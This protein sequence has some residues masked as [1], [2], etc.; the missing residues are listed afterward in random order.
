M[1]ASGARGTHESNSATRPRALHSCE[2]QFGSFGARQCP[3]VSR[4]RALPGPAIGFLKSLLESRHPQRWRPALLRGLYGLLGELSGAHG[5]T[6]P[7][8]DDHGLNHSFKGL[9]ITFVKRSD[10]AKKHGKF[11][12]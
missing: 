8:L 3:A 6:D 12:I 7:A 1:G 5:F 11:W 2:P 4:G 9:A 10:L